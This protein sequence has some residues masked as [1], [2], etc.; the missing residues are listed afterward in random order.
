[1]GMG[2]RVCRAR[3]WLHKP[4]TRTNA[5]DNPTLSPF[6][7]VLIWILMSLT[8]STITQAALSLAQTIRNGVDVGPI[9]HQLKKHYPADTSEC[10]IVSGPPHYSRSARSSCS[11]EAKQG[12][13]FGWH[14]SILWSIGVFEWF[15]W[16]CIHFHQSPLHSSTQEISVQHIIL[17]FRKWTY[18]STYICTQMTHAGKER[19]RKGEE[20][21]RS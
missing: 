4:D 18:T 2:M 9:L 14:S 20:R 3:A 15:L 10:D 19:E 21:E 16:L 7:L 1:M 13:S 12:N 8:T 5:H 17:R 11:V 6:S